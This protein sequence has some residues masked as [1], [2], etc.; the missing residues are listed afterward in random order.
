M[1]SAARQKLRHLGIQDPRVHVMRFAAEPMVL[2]RQA[3]RVVA[4][5]GYNTI[6]EILSAGKK[7]V[8]VPRIRPVQ[9]QFIRAQR[10]DELGLIKMVHPD[11]LTP[12][13]LWDAVQ[14]AARMHD[15]PEKIAHSIDLNG[16]R[17][18]ERLVKNHFSELAQARTSAPLQWESVVS[19][20]A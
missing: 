5:G 15:L 1:P 7:A 16:L 2:Y 9:E 13:T 20:Y 4:M 10:L 12:A 8:I 17:N 3:E 18:I 6:C 14:S 19:E 11:A